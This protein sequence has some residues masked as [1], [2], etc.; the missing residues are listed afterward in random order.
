MYLKQLK[1]INSHKSKRLLT[2]FEKEH[3]QTKIY[4]TEMSYKL[5]A[6]DY[7]KQQFYSKKVN[8]T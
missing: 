5:L 3:H 1:L 6:S 7:Q 2:G 8:S 4:G